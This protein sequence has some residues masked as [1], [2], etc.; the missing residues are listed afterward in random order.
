[1]RRQLPFQIATF[2]SAFL[3]F[4]VQPI[5]AK[6]LLPWFGGAPAVWTACLLFFQLGLTAGYLY[7]HVLSRFSIKWQAALHIILLLAALLTL[8]IVV[9]AAWKPGEPGVPAA[10]ALHV[11]LA[12]MATA[13]IPYVLLAATAPLLQSWWRQSSGKEPYRLYALSNAGSLVALLSFPTLVEPVLTVS[14]Q[15]FVWS[16]IYVAFLLSC[17]GAASVA[18]RAPSGSEAYS[19]E[20]SDD[21]RPGAGDYAVWILLSSCGSGLLA[22][23]TNQLCQ[24][25]AVIPLLWLLPLAVYLV[26]FIVTFGGRY[27][28]FASMVVL[29]IG[30]VAALLA[31]KYTAEMPMLLQIAAFLVLLA[32]ACMVCHGELVAA[33]P[34]GAG[35]TS[36]YLAMSAGGALGGAFVALA[37]PRLFTSFTELPIFVLIALMV[38]V[39]PASRLA[40][41]QSR[42]RMA[43]AFFWVLPAVALGVSIPLLPSVQ[44]I[45]GEL[46]DARRDFFGVLRVRDHG[47]DSLNPWRG[48]YHGRVLHGAQFIRSDTRG[49]PTTY[50]VDGSGIAL[51]FAQHSRRLAG[52]PIKAGIVGLGTGTVAALGREGDELVFFELNPNV[53]D[54]ARKSFSFLGDSRAHTRVVPGDARLSLERELANEPSRAPYDLIVVDAFAGDSVPVHLLTRECFALYVRALAP[55]GVMV[56][57]VSNRHID[58]S[59]PVHGLAAWAGLSAAELSF[60]GSSAPLG[61]RSDWILVT[62]D[63]AF[64]K[65]AIAGGAAPLESSSS[66]L[67]TDDYSSILRLLR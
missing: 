20:T 16:S 14:M 38:A 39:L 55:G 11:V 32:G 24:D 40:A 30:A 52:L 59:A 23:A 43:L 61:G 4:L 63:A 10:P 50:Y 48:L 31:T 51:A 28:R 21:R 13:G 5:L 66:V 58:L 29:V 1:M 65:R 44:T 19:R 17:A 62:G 47:Q 3:L 60:D 56:V 27:P 35:L 22:A 9:P 25:V 26:T 67:W 36:F 37:A 42:H 46:V 53:T 15:A 57:H 6:Q 34:T 7:A 64:L 8:P 45:D 33:R 54:I 49:T 12:L 18:R 41:G 2:V